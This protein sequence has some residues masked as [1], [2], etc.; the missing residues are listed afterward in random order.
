MR[1]QYRDLKSIILSLIL[2][3]LIGFALSSSGFAQESGSENHERLISMSFREAELDYVLD[4]FSRA[5]GYTVV[6][7]AEI[8]A[9]V[10]IISQKDIPVDQAFSVL[11]SILAIKGY[12]TIVNGKIVKV[13]PLENAKQENMEIRVGSDPTD[14]DIADTIVTQIMPLSY[15]SAGQIVKDLKDLIPKYGVMIAHTRSNTLIVTAASSNINRFAQII[16]ELDIP[17]SD[18]IKIE[19]FPVKYRDAEVLAKVI[20]KMFEK[21]KGTEAEQQAQAERGRRF[22]GFDR[23]PGGA[24]EEASAETS[25]TGESE[26]LQIMGDVKVAADTDTNSI[27][28]SASQENLNLIRELIEKLDKPVTDQAETRIFILEHADSSELADKLNQAFQPSTSRYSTQTGFGRTR[29]G[30]GGGFMP[31]QANQ[32]QTTSEGDSILGLP[33]VSVVGDER[34][35]SLIVTTTSQQ[36]ESMGQLIKQLDRDVADYEQDTMV[37][38]LENAEAANME[39]VLSELFETTTFEQRRGRTTTSARGGVMG[40]AAETIETARGLAGNVKVVAEETTNSLIITTYK[41]NFPAVEK[42]IK[43]LDV[44]LPQV[45]IEVKIVEITLDDD[46]KF[47]VE[48]MWEHTTSVG[49]RKYLK[50]GSTAF[51]LADEVFGMKY[52]I[53]GETL[54]TLLMALEKNTKVNILS[55]PRILTLDNHEAVINIGQEVPYLESTQETA[56]GG[57][58]TSYDFRDE[59]VILTVLPRINKSE[60]VTMDVNQQINS[61]IEFTL[62]NA[63]VITKREAVASVTV[64]DGQ[65]M[66]IG[67]IIQDNKTE[68]IHKVPILGSIPFIGGLFRRQESKIEK[69]E[70]MV[71]ITPHIV[72][73]PEEAD[74]VTQK[75]RYDLILPGRKGS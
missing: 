17:M 19:V 12:A 49:S 65:T 61:L 58:L 56:T 18:L 11:N 71:F 1:H 44:M 22:R 42:L 9:R 63:P 47:G 14:I 10:T 7:D 53:L 60:T 59:G 24:G 50:S 5:T 28:V 54:E 39:Q 3:V 45:L 6:K 26:R 72:R 62:F 67:G 74:K 25:A 75:Q 68:T 48:W 13:V 16:K 30:R 37:I 46:T 15:T 40:T 43:E 23:G 41:R 20:E 35:N 64:K 21:P 70:L 32:T 36:M 73:N 38:S 27:V 52:G 66:I 31:P 34:T 29:F 57:V 4:F 51:G 8:K 33:E 55:T 69:T 2:V